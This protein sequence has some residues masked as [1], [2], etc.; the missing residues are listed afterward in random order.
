[1]SVD[2]YTPIYIS[3]CYVLLIHVLGAFD[4][5]SPHAPP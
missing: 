4:P 3:V 2:E 1:M 5:R